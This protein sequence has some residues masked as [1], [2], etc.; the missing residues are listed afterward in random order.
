[1]SAPYATAAAAV[2]GEK[3]SVPPD[4][5]GLSTTSFAV[6]GLLA[7]RPWSTYELAQQM[8]RGLYY[9]WQSAESGVYEEPKKLVARGLATA[10]LGHVGRRRRTV[11][12][13]TPRGREVLRRWLGTAPAPARLAHEALVRVWMGEQGT[14][15]Q[16]LEAIHCIRRDA[17]DI[18]SHAAHVAAEYLGDPPPF[19]ERLHVNTLVLKFV[20]DYAAT[21]ARWCAWAEREVA[22]WP[23]VTMEAGA[24]PALDVLRAAAAWD[25]H[26]GDEVTGSTQASRRPGG[27]T[28]RA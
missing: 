2:N 5:R 6:L 20:A 19:P 18:L 13:I 10:E 21:A 23:G 27:R 8:K 11:Y 3:H 7:L 22:S 1:V 26:A 14:Q 15:E 28:R 16:L 9:F 24:A 12:T 4:E 25:G 17:Q